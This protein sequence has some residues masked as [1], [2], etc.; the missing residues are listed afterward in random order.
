MTRGLPI[1][2]ATKQA[3]AKNMFH[4]DRAEIAALRAEVER[5]TAALQEIEF[6]GGT[7]AAIARYV[8]EPKP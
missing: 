7:A 8:L 5:L 6:H 4:S 1:S 2:K 3:I